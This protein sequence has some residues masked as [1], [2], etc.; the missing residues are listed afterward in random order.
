MRI[1]QP[2]PDIHVV[3]GETYNSNSVVFTNGDE[4]LLVDCL[5]SR[6]D[7]EALRR[8]IEDELGKRVRFIIATHYFRDHLAALKLFPEADIIAHRNYRQVFDSEMY[9]SEE[10]NS[11]F[12]EPTLLVSDGLEMRWGQYRL[13]VFY[14]PGHTVGTLCVDV[15]LADMILTGDTVVGNIAYLY[16]TTPEA[17]ARALRSLEQRSRRRLI[18]SHMGVRSTDAV[19]NA[20]FYMDRLREEIN[21]R[22]AVDAHDAVLK[23]ELEDCVREGVEATR[24]EKMFHQRNL[25]TIVERNLFAPGL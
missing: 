9:Y 15:P 2:E 6:E 5:G 22:R 4:V 18:G 14:N 12:V 7:A 8:F 24:F 3:I 13:D 1:Q 25:E 10:E 20:V 19:G 21:A 23:V 11:F 17:M 16:Y